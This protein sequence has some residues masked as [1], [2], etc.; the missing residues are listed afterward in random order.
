MNN[1]IKKIAD[2]INL[3]SKKDQELRNR[4]FATNYKPTNKDWETLKKLDK[5]NSEIVKKIVDEYG[6][7][8]ISKFSKKASFNAWLIVQHAVHDLP[9]MKKYLSLMKSNLEEINLQNYAYLQDRLLLIDKKPQIYGT[10]VIKDKKT[11]KFKPNKLK[12][13]VKKTDILRKKIGLESIE[14]YLNEFNI[15]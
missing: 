14:K 8:T 13:S 3:L 15:D 11:N 9:F 1:D 10:Q 7:I 12:Y 2:K 5:E 6:L 4:I